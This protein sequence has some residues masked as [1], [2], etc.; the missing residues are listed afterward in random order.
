MVVMQSRAVA[1]IQTR[2]RESQGRAAKIK[3]ILSPVHGGLNFPA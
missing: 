1:D 3:R 2:D